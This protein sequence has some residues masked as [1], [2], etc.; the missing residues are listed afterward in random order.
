[1]PDTALPRGAPTR[2]SRALDPGTRPSRTACSRPAPLT[3][4]AT[5]GTA[6]EKPPRSSPA[7][8]RPVFSYAIRSALRLRGRAP[9]TCSRSDR[10]KR[11]ITRA[12]DS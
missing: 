6:G 3:G 4:E 9:L 5:I 12:H 8:T 11:S 7:G 1:M 2:N 10:F